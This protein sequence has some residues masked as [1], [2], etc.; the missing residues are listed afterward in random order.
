MVMRWSKLPLPLEVLSHM[1]FVMVIICMFSLVDKSFI[2]WLFVIF[3][4][5]QSGQCTC[6][7]LILALRYS[8]LYIFC[9]LGCILQS[10]VTIICSWNCYVHCC[11]VYNRG[12]CDKAPSVS[13]GYT[14]LVWFAVF[15]E[16]G[17]TQACSSALVLKSELHR[18]MVAKGFD[19][20]LTI[21]YNRELLRKQ[22]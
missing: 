6:K 9:L 5:Q 19:H 1:I 14:L 7:S 16:N 18:P 12:R 10:E 17:F 11:Q 2:I 21:I 8:N 13:R 3:K 4:F 20:A 22:H 15:C